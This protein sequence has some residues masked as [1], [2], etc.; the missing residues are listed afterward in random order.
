MYPLRQRDERI[1]PSRTYY[2]QATPGSSSR[3]ATGGS[4]S[5]APR[6]GN[7]PQ[8]SHPL[9]PRPDPL[10]FPRPH[11]FRGREHP[12]R[13]HPQRGG[14]PNYSTPSVSNF[15]PTA[16]KSTYPDIHS[17]LDLP[18]H[19]D[20]DQDS[21]RIGS[22]ISTMSMR[23]SRASAA[24]KYSTPHY[25]PPPGGR[26]H[27]RDGELVQMSD[28][29]DSD[30]L[31]VTKSITGSSQV[32]RKS[33]KV[34]AR[35]ILSTDD[36]PASSAVRTTTPLAATLARPQKA[37]RMQEIVIIS[38]DSEEEDPQEDQAGFLAAAAS[39]RVGIRLQ[40][41]KRVPFLL[42]N[43]RKSFTRT[44]ELR[45]VPTLPPKQPEKAIKYTYRFRIPQDLFP[46]QVPTPR[47]SEYRELVTEWRCPF[48]DLLGRLNTEQMLRYHLAQGHADV[49][50]TWR[51]EGDTGHYTFHLPELTQDEPSEDD[52]EEEDILRVQESS[53]DELEYVDLPPRLPSPTST[54]EAPANARQHTSASPMQVDESDTVEINSQSSRTTP[55]TSMINIALKHEDEE[56]ALQRQPTP[57]GRVPRT[58]ITE[59]GEL[60]PPPETN[61]LG[62]AAE[63]PL[64]S[65]RPGGPRIYDL[66][67]ELPLEPYGILAWSIVDREEEIYEL[68]DVMDEDKVMMALW[69]RWIFLNRV[70]FTFHREGETYRSGVQAFIDEYYVMIHRAA[71]WAALRAFLIVLAANKFLSIR[72]V[73]KLLCHY[74]KQVKRSE[75]YKVK[76]A[77]FT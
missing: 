45:G 38:S 75:W 12:F 66:L 4:D 17:F 1:P 74:D 21:R 49:Q 36:L 76:P 56:I 15:Y 33:T 64:E 27:L 18:Q 67:N 24:R 16:T 57:P 9:P 26:V 54:V 62:P 60:V 73:L 72:D 3:P 20:N 69:N 34:A 61:P 5:F 48:C 28:D 58:G 19:D 11:Q 22:R 50:M 44:C 35:G 68:A 53:D 63:P 59:M 51:T 41:H 29:E 42:Q 7:S 40:V 55:P 39:F 23:S 32:G 31:R 37:K 14:A 52:E 13:G 71:G 10:Q 30:D 47:W 65:C 43:L 70:K 25:T 2:P 8:V 6:P 46:G 77:G